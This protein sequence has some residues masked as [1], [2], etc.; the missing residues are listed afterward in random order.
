MTSYKEKQ[1]PQEKDRTSTWERMGKIEN[2]QRQGNAACKMD[3][4]EV[5]AVIMGYQS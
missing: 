4:T 3:S 5:P 1:G 2:D